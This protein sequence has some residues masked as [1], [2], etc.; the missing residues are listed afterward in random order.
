MNHLDADAIGEL[1]SQ[2]STVVNT[3]VSTIVTENKDFAHSVGTEMM[4]LLMERFQHSSPQPRVK[5]AGFDFMSSVFRVGQIKDLLKDVPD[6]RLVLC[7]VIGDKSGGCNAYVDM[8][9][10]KKGDGPMMITVGHPEI[11][12]ISATTDHNERSLM[13]NEMIEQLNRLR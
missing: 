1:E 13:I 6:D 12:H 8:G 9:M 10:L 11:A 3:V 2:M 4:G 5:V 7:Q